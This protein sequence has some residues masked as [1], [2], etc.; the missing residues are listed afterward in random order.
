MKAVAA[1]ALVQLPNLA[2]VI[3]Q[4]DGSCGTNAAVTMLRYWNMNHRADNVDAG[5][6]RRSDVLF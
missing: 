2:P 3:S 1:G 6:I 4:V 5:P